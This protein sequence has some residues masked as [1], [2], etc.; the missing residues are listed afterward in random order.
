MPFSD[1]SSNHRCDTRFLGHEI[2][3]DKRVRGAFETIQAGY[4][5]KS[6]HLINV[7]RTP[8]DALMLLVPDSFAGGKIGDTL[9]TY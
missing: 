8:H 5:L 6:C 4:R 9:R 3:A 1:A 7:F 2:C